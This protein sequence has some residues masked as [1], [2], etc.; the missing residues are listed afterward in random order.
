MA[1]GNPKYGGTNGAPALDMGQE[2]GLRYLASTARGTFSVVRNA[3]EVAGQ[4]HHLPQQNVSVRD[5]MGF[6]RGR[7]RWD[8]VLRTSTTAIFDAIAAELDSYRF[9]AVFASGVTGTFD[10]TR[11]RETQLTDVN[12]EVIAERAVLA[13]WRQVTRR[14]RND[15]WGAIARMQVEFEII[16]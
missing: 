13:D 3:T 11:V 16:G 7:V 15:E 2:G 10:P 12:G 14:I 4:L 9:G 6:V 5:V 1:D 8:V